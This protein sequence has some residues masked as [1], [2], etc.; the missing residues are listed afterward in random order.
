MATARDEFDSATQGGFNNYP[1]RATKKIF[2]GRGSTESQ[3]AT[4]ASG[5]VLKAYTFL[6]SNSA[7]KLIAHSGLAESAQMVVT[8]ALT[9]GLTQIIAGLT[10]TSGASGTTASQLAAAWNNN[11]L[12][13]GVG[14]GFAALTGVTNAVNGGTFTAGTLANYSTIVLSTSVANEVV[15]NASVAGNLTDIAVTGT[16]TA[17]TVSIVQGSANA[18][19]IAGVTMYDVDATSGDTVAEVY[20]EASFWGDDDGNVA[21]LWR[22]DPLVDTVTSALGV[23]VAVTAYNTGCSGITAASHLLKKKFVEASEFELGFVGI[24]DRL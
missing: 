4:I 17:P 22:V 18:A 12:G 16:G 2:Y 23:S 19:T 1:N 15:F 9:V 5:Q 10:F 6:E 21:L 3:A 8:A 20:R 11:G 14:T 7:G 13:I 24:G